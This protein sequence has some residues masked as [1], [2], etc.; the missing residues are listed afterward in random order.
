MICDGLKVAGLLF[1]WTSVTMIEIIGKSTESTVFTFKYRV[2][3]FSNV[4]R[5]QSDDETYYDDPRLWRKL[6]SE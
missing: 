2:V 6:G 3:I 4:P 1:P 5:K